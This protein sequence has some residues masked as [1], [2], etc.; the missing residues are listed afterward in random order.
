[1]DAFSSELNNLL[2]YTFRSI[3]KLEEQSLDRIAKGITLNEMHMLE[4]VA[5]GR[6]AGRSISDIAGDLGI[7]LPSVTMAVNKLVRKGFLVKQK[8]EEDKRVVIVRLAPQGRRAE[9]AHRFFH[10][11]M[12]QD[13]TKDLTEDEEAAMLK[14]MRKLRAFFE[15]QEHALEQM[16][17]PAFPNPSQ[18]ETD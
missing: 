10:R 17:P 4:A 3:L 15:K 6:E 5:G 14:G 18:E 2:V 1:M 13:I 12:V 11:H 16:L 9:A 7:T 8:S